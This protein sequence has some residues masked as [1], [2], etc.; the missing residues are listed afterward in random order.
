MTVPDPLV[1]A[2]IPLLG[3]AV[4]W[5]GQQFVQSVILRNRATA[6]PERAI[7]PPAPPLL[8]PQL[9]VESY[10]Q[11]AELMKQ[12]LNGRYMFAKEARDRFGSVETKIDGLGRD[13][14][15]FISEHVQ[16]NSPSV[17]GG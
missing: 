17:G 5:I 7:A 4:V 13:M 11:I 8:A 14:K 12:E 2:S 15:A 3:G 1:Y 6:D 16:A 10:R 9:T